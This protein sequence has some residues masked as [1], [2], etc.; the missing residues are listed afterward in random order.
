MNQLQADESFSP[1]GSFV[2]EEA[3]FKKIKKLTSKIPGTAGYVWGNIDRPQYSYAE[4]NWGLGQKEQGVNPSLYASRINADP[5][6]EAD[7]LFT[8]NVLTGGGVDPR[9]KFKH[10]QDLGSATGPSYGIAPN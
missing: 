4:G 6:R 7:Y 5:T 1:T 3:A 2:D 8:S 10:Y 9:V